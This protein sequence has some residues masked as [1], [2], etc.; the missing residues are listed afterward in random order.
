MLIQKGSASYPLIVCMPNQYTGLT[1]LAQLSKNGG[2]F[3]LPAGGTTMEEIGRGVY[4]IPGNATDTN[5]LGPLVISCSS[6]GSMV[7]NQQIGDVVNYDPQQ[8]IVAIQS[9]DTALTSS[10]AALQTSINAIHTIDAT[11]QT[12]VQTAVYVTRTF[13]A[14]FDGYDSDGRHIVIPA[15]GGTASVTQV[16]SAAWLAAY[17][18]IVS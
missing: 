18:T 17:P 2:A 4:Q 11:I 10:V 16:T 9:L 7:L 15:G 5:T 12:D 6:S 13:N 14:A 1:L 8:T 3:G